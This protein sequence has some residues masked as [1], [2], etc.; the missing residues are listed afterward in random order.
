MRLLATMTLVLSMMLT[1]TADDD[2]AKKKKRG[3]RQNALVGKVKEAIGSL[4]LTEEQ[5]TKIEEAVT[6][7]TATTKELQKA[8]YNQELRKARTEAMKAAREAGGKQKEIMAGVKAK[9]TDEQNELFAKVQEATVKMKK[10]VLA[11]LGEDNV[12]KLPEQL[13]KTLK[14]GTQARGNRKGKGKKAE[15]AS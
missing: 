15:A 4:D 9:F 6:A 5:K 12:A 14:Q 3:A 11:A 13:Q 2:A 8:G 1:A 7:F 10:S